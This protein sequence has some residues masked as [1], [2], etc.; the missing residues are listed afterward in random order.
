MPKDKIRAITIARYGR[1]TKPELT[2][3]TVPSPKGKQLLIKVHAASINPRDWLLMRGIYPF[4]KL[5]E[6]FPITLGSDMSGTVTE[7]GSQVSSFK[8]G[9]QVFGMQPIRGKFGAFADYA[10]IEENAVAL[11]PDGIGHTDAAAIPCAGLT[12]FQA[13]H[14]IAKLCKA[15]TILINGASGGVGSYAIQIAKAVGANV[16]AVCGPDNIELCKELG[17]DT[18]INYKDQKFENSKNEYDVIF[19]VIGR[20]SFKK[21]KTTLKK[22]GRYITTIPAP[23]TVLTAFLSKLL[24]LNPFGKRQTA[25]LVLVKPRAED[26]ACMASMM[27]SGKLRSLID[28]IY[29]LD[30]AQTAFDKSQSWRTKGKLIFKG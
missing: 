17:A 6:P 5:A 21:C 20:S 9:D 7:V 16:V 11:K 29:S 22:G 10:L 27:K 4:K 28:T 12:A 24:Y 13:I 8:V 23:N 18:V 2:E 19:D 26:L 30:E 3:K 25:H 1:N 14:S 15:E